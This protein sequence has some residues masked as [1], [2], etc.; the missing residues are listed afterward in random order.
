MEIFSFI[1]HCRSTSLRMLT[2]SDVSFTHEQMRV[3]IQKRRGKALHRHLL[4]DFPWSSVWVQSNLI[5]ILEKMGI[6]PTGQSWV[7]R[8][9]SGA[10]LGHC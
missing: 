5:S 9:D 4:L 6:I 1:F 10:H 3:C 2:P 8:L 7:L